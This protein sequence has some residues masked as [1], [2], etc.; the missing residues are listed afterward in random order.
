MLLSII[1]GERHPR[2]LAAL[3]LVMLGLPGGIRLAI[4]RIVAAAQRR[5]E[6]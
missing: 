1:A 6:E 3:V 2:W 4:R 5:D